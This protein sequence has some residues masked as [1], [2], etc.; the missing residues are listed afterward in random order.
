MDRILGTL[1]PQL[2]KLAAC[3][4]PGDVAAV[5]VDTVQVCFGS[6]MG[7]VT[8][9]QSSKGAQAKAPWGIRDSDAEEYDRHWSGQDCVFNECMRRATP[10]HNWQLHGE[11]AWRKTPVQAGY[12]RRLGVWHLMMVPLFGD[13]GTLNGVVAM[14]RRSGASAYGNRDV[15][16][17][18]ALSGFLSATLARVRATPRVTSPFVGHSRLTPREL[19]VARLASRGRNNLQI[20][21]ELGLARETIKQTLRR[22]YVKL[23]VSGR[24]EMAAHLAGLQLV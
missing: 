3:R 10:V 14:G 22:V 15:A 21:L 4:T 13:D 8:L 11:D 1:G 20:A 2:V 23:D 9:V 17:A 19:Q 18:S 24:A 16:M 6:P 12:G 5:A 7:M